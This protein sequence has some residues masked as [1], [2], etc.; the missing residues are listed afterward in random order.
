MIF[1]DDPSS[2]VDESEMR[3]SVGILIQMRNSTCEKFFKAKGYKQV[4]LP[5]VTAV[6]VSHPM[7][8]GIGL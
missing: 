7:H 4:E 8:M 1:Y 2:L 3:L 6:G 5:R